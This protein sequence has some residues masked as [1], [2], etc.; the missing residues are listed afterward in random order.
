MDLLL[1][2]IFKDAFWFAVI[3]STTPILFAT[4]GAVVASRAGAINIGIEGTMLTG[5]LMGVIFSAYTQNVWIGL[6]AAVL[7]GILVSML[8]GYFALKLRTNIVLTGIAIN[9]LAA[10]GTVFLLAELT[11]DK[12]I[13]TSLNSLV[14]PNVNIPIINSIP[15]IGN[16]LSGHN[17]LTY[18]AILCIILM[19]ILFNNMSLGLR[20]KAVGES[21]EAAES[22][23]I[24]V[25]R[26]K[27]IALIISGIFAAL[28]G[29]FLSMGYVSWFSSGMTAGRGFIALAAR[30]IAGNTSLGSLFA[31]FLFGFADTL[32]NYLQ[33]F[34]IPVEFIHMTPYL[35]TII[36]FIVISIINDKKELE[37]KKKQMN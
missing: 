17:I 14:L 34:S 2:M 12:G 35:V 33:E 9:I 13:S 20:I 8:L 36:G 6:L 37:R 7:S 4:L 22:V 27:F 31:S 30:A 29:A 21:P 16:I 1:S 15:V 5:A 25:F 24:D 3:R 26:I 18:V 10:G 32:S 11:G 19:H 23:G 28:G